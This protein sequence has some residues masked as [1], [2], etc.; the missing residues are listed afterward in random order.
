[1]PGTGVTKQCDGRARCRTGERRVK[2][3]RTGTSRRRRM[4][5]RRTPAR[6]RTVQLGDRAYRKVPGD[7]SPETAGAT[8]EA[9]RLSSHLWLQ[10]TECVSFVYSQPRLIPPGQAQLPG[11]H[12]NQSPNK[13][14][15]AGHR[16]TTTNAYK[17]NVRRRGLAT[18]GIRCAARTVSKLTNA[19]AMVRNTAGRD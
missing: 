6:T 11:S 14:S 2:T 18:H 7:I 19:H 17:I 1:M 4:E 5:A 15:S 13:S 9:R 10:I 16:Y 3:Y 8:I 12:P